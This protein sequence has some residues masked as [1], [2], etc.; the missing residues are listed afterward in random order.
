MHLPYAQG[1]FASTIDNLLAFSHAGLDAV[2]VAE[3][4]SFDAVS[5][6][7]FIAARSSPS[8]RSGCARRSCRSTP[9]PHRSPP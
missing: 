8:W 9:V 5:Q 2:S 4:Y 1:G 6:L 7:G 3:L